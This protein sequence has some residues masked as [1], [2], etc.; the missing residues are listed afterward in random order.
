[1]NWPMINDEVRRQ[2]LELP[3]GKIDIVLDTDT[4]NE[5][6][7]QFAL[8]HAV[9]SPDRINLKAIYAAPFFNE[10]SANAK[11]GME[12]SYE[13]IKRLLRLINKPELYRGPILKGSE[14]FMMN[15]ED[16]ISS[17]AVDDLIA[18]G[19]SRKENSPLY[20]VAI[21]AI[22]N[23]AAALIQ[24]PR[25]VDHIVVIWLGGHDLHWTNTREFNLKQ[26]IYAANTV[27]DSGVPLILLPC[28]GVSSHMIV[29]NYELAACIGNTNKICDTLIQLVSEYSDREIGWSKP[30]WD[31][32]AIGVILDNSWSSCYL[33][34]SPRVTDNLLWSRDNNRHSI[35]V[36][37]SLNRNAIFADMYRKLRNI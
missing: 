16:I 36:V 23:I 17:E 22:T 25:L 3:T 2:R 34:S 26:D 28:M 15:A 8:C 24:E 14:R 33:T 13:E 1:M 12:Q 9:L 30:L 37:Q 11:D 35:K 32:A 29:S 18:R 10:R 20:V 27:F 6:D 19:M 5:V 31:V 21:G 7:D 4:F